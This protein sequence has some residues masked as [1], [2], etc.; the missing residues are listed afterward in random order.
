MIWH[1]KEEVPKA[2]KNIIIQV[3]ICLRGKER[4]METIC[5][6]PGCQQNLFYIYQDKIV[7]WAYIADIE[8]LK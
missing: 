5:N 1:T 6:N 8:K 3:M 7:R 4:K 2:N